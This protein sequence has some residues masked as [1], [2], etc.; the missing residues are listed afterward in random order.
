MYGLVRMFAIG[1]IIIAAN[2]W[3]VTPNYSH[4]RSKTKKKKAFQYGGLQITQ[5]ADKHTF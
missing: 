2:I 5:A 1:N 4:L 3:T